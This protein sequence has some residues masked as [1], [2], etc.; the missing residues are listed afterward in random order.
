[1]NQKVNLNLS[2]EQMQHLQTLP[3]PWQQYQ[4][5]LEYM[6]QK[7]PY[8]EYPSHVHLEMMAKC[9]AACVFCPYP[10]LDRQGTKMP[11]ELI[12]KVLTE[13]EEIPKHISFQLSP[14]KVSEPFL[15]VRLFD[16]LRRINE[17]LPNAKITLTSNATPITQGKLDELRKIQHIEYLWISFNHHEKEGYEATMKLPYERTIE[18]LKLIHRYKQEGRMYFPIVLSRVGD[19]SADDQ[20]FIRFVQSEFPAFSFSIFPRGDW[21]GQSGATTNFPVPNMGCK[22]WFEL[23]ITA[24]GEV[25]HCCMDG[26][27]KWPIG[28]VRDHTVLEIYNSPHYRRLRE[29]TMTRM[30][31]EPCNKCSFM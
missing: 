1:M 28:N 11:D 7:S 10:V 16:V 12:D 4:L 25:A 20:A 18:R 29:D 19:G 27:A 23:S 3:P 2:A 8:M 30:S 31:E 5:E 21:L 6:R 14:F 26:Q 22:R 24:T 9:N 15:D 17:R 13:L